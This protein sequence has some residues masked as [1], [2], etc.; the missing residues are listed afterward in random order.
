[1]N[2]VERLRRASQP[3]DAE[4]EEDDEDKSVFDM[5]DDELREA[6][7]DAETWEEAGFFQ[8]EMN[9]RLLEKITVKDA[10]K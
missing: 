1:M 5:T 7:D 3:V 9:R 10:A 8:L 6:V 4:P 2:I